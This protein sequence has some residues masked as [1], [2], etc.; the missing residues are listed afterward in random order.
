M[1]EVIYQKSCRLIILS[2]HSHESGHLKDC[3]HLVT[4]LVHSKLSDLG[5]VSNTIESGVLNKILRP[6]GIR[7]NRRFSCSIKS[8]NSHLIPPLSLFYDIIDVK[9][10][11]IKDFSLLPL[12]EC[13]LESSIENLLTSLKLVLSIVELDR[14][15]RRCKVINNVSNF[16]SILGHIIT[17]N[18]LKSVPRTLSSDCSNNFLNVDNVVDEAELSIIFLRSVLSL[19]YTLVALENS[20][21]ESKIIKCLLLIYLRSNYR[22]EVDGSLDSI[23]KNESI[24][25]TLR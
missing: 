18:D 24:N 1:S 13:N 10:I 16:T 17:I 11:D 21:V 12:I 6:Y 4:L 14:I 5:E 23:T 9:D 3:Q 25:D 15:E 22:S 7:I 19:N 2:E 8:I 20:I